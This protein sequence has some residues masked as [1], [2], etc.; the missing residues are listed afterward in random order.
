MELEDNVYEETTQTENGIDAG[1]GE[2]AQKDS[3][4][5]GK[6]KDVDALV[7]AYSALQ[8]EFTRRSQRLKELEKQSENSKAD[9]AISGAEK[10]RKTAEARRTAAKAFDEFVATVGKVQPD[11]ADGPDA[12]NLPSDDVSVEEKPMNEGL[13]RETETQETHSVKTM[14]EEEVSQT[15]ETVDFGGKG[16][17]VGG[18]T[19]VQPVANGGNVALSSDELYAKVCC[20]EGVRLRIIGEYLTSIGRSSAPITATAGSAGALASP[21]MRARNLGEASQMAL[22][23][24]KK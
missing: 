16:A 22:Q 18:E 1:K 24:L 11:S 15:A 19:T 7:R 4:V 20:D 21:P 17:K 13:K 2:E 9:K 8:S 23:F 5:L 12:E 3:A 6:F 10:L 14:T